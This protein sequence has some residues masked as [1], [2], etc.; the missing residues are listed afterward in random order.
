MNKFCKICNDEKPY[1]R[2]DIHIQ[3]KHNMTLEEYNVFDPTQ[4]E[5]KEFVPKAPISR[6]EVINNIFDNKAAESSKANKPL[7]EFLKEFDLSEQD[8]RA[9][10]KNY[11]E[12]K[13][14]PYQQQN[15]LNERNGFSEAR[16][17]SSSTIVRTH[18]LYAAEAL[19]KHFNYKCVTVK[20]A[21]NNTPK[22]W[23]LERQG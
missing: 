23:V 17:L 13:P 9:I 14:L 10:V 6:K 22:V 4:E 5:V 7:R 12:G 21:T 16:K 20:S 11:K 18:N 2:L 1:K 15:S 8:L 3:N 19:E